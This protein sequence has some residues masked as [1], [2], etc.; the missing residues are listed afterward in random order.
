[1]TNTTKTTRQ[2]VSINGVRTVLTTRN[3]RVTTKPALPK[4][5]EL[6]AAQVRALRALPEYA[7][8]A[9]SVGPGMFTLAGDQNA[10][11]RGPKARAEAIAAGMTPGEHDLRIYMFGGRLGLIE[12]KVGKAKLLPAQEA[13]HPLLAALGFDKQAVI[14]AVTEEDA[15]RQA[16]ELVRGWL[17]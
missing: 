17:L 1:M 4:E 3:G 8:T 14:R 7:A 5:W 10:A 15:A 11:K 12:N 6:Q 2:T 13:R 9:R 16:V